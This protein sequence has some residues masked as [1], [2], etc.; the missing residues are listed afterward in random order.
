MIFGGYEMHFGVRILLLGCLLSCGCA[1]TVETSPYVRHEV[2]RELEMMS[3]PEYRV[4]PPDVL[5]I[6][7]VDNIRH[8]GSL[9]Q[10]GDTVFIQVANTLP[11]ETFLAENDQELGAYLQLE[12]AFKNVNANYLIDNDGMADLGP[13]Y[14]K[15]KLADL[16]PPQAEQA[17]AEHL[18]ASSVENPKVSVA[19]IDIAA[20]QPIAGEHLVRPDGTVSL[21]TYGSVYVTGMTVNEIRMVVE[22]R[23][24]PHLN[25]PKANVDIVAYNSKSFYVITD[26]GGYGEQVI[27]LPAV[28]NETVLDAVAQIEGLSQVS[29]KNIWIA[30]PAPSNMG[31]AQILPVNWTEISREGVTATNY[32]LMPGDRLYIQADPLIKLDNTFAKIIS[33]VE[34]VFGVVL[35]GDQMLDSFRM[36]GQQGGFGNF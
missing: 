13:I 12:Q 20:K 32:Q 28:G 21:G 6:E 35:L 3:L 18:K 22:A 11:Y 23:L 14:G 10:P 31:V 36:T 24:K 17:I 29:S 30:R 34:R 25:N 5:I 26:G 7:V 27:R 8:E 15:L 33:P 4:A 9:L 2:P 16:T 19:L 1:H